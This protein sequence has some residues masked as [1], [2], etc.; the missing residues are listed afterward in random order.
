MSSKGINSKYEE[1]CP[2]HYYF[3][4]EVFLL[5]YFRHT[6][7]FIRPIFESAL[8]SKWICSKQQVLKALG[9]LQH[10]IEKKNRRKR[11]I[12]NTTLFLIY[13]ILGCP[14]RY[15]YGLKLQIVHELV[16]CT[17]LF[18]INSRGYFIIFTV[19]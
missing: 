14:S 2:M 4:K 8:F 11:M 6:A 1:Q 16:L 18:S 12:N 3:L 19:A 7:Q 9:C 15:C 13:Y 10:V 17:L 5:T